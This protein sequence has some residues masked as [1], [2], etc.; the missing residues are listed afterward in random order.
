[1]VGLF[2]FIGNLVGMLLVGWVIKC[3]GFNCSYYFVLLIFVVGC[4][5]LGIIVGFWI[6]LSWCFIVGVGC[7][8]IWVVVESVLV[9][10]GIFCS[11]GCL[12]VVYM[13]V[14]YVGIVLG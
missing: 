9:C 7:V 5:G 10:S 8:M 2:Y 1:M 14:Y 4:V 3:L 12:L 6:W 11:C 13:M